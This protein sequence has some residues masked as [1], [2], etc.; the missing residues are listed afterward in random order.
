VT[1]SFRCSRSWRGLRF[2]AGVDE[3][4]KLPFDPS[5]AQVELVE[6]HFDAP[7]DRL[8]LDLQ[9]L[10]LGRRH[11]LGD[12]ECDDRGDAAEN[13]TPITITAPPTTRP[14]DVT[15]TWSPYPTVVKVVRAHHRESAQEPNVRPGTFRSISHAADPPST[16]AATAVNDTTA[17]MRRAAALVLLRPL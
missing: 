13:P 4:T 1:G 6:S 5:Q 10:L 8:G 9:H 12:D 11:G 3:G 15:G 7:L 17:P 16:T 14:A 2:L